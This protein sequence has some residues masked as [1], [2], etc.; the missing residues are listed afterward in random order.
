MRP[1]KFRLVSVLTLWQRRE[2]AAL[3]DLLRNQAATRDADLRLSG[4]VETRADAA[5][6]THVAVAGAR[7]PDDPAWHRNWI[8]HLSMAI[9]AARD[10]LNRCEALERTA[11]VVWQGAQRDRR[12][13]ERLRDRAWRRHQSEAR[14]NEMKVMDEL[15]GLRARPL[16]PAG[17]SGEHLERHT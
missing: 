11:R 7:L 4:L 15:A 6:R 8:V 14:R 13:L 3:A 16:P 12:M 5:R 10:D 17:T 1:F 2:D 9:E